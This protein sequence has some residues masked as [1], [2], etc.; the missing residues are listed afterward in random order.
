MPIQEWS[1]TTIIAQLSDEPLFSE[2]F[3]SLM[4]RVTGTPPTPDVIINLQDVTALNSSNL[5]QLIKLRDAVERGG[6][7]LRICSLS[8]TIW[9]VFLVTRLDRLFEF[10][11]DVTT[12]LT[13]LQLEEDSR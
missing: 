10:T 9:S 4:R 6:S 7:R 8:D 5:A 12:S 3:E 11:D 2:D 1:E 13:S